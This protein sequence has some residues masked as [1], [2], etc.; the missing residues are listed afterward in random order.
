M[1]TQLMIL[2]IVA[3]MV[4]LAIT[5]M[6]I[7]AL[8]Q[9][10]NLRVQNS[11]LQTSLDEKQQ[12][13]QDLK[14]QTEMHLEAKRK[15][16]EENM[17]LREHVSA[18]NATL[19]AND[20]TVKSL[21]EQIDKLKQD[22]A[23]MHSKDVTNTNEITRLS[24]LLRQA[25]QNHEELLKRQAEL[26][27]QAEETFR[28]IATDILKQNTVDFK[29]ANETR[30]REI[31]TPFRENVDN[32]RK[33]I[34]EYYE[35]GIKETAS[36]KST[37]AELTKLNN[38]LSQEASELATALRGNKR[39]TQGPWGEMILKQILESSGLIEGTNF[40]LQ[41]TTNPDG[42]KIGN[43]YRP[44]ALLYF[45]DN[46][47]LV[48]DSKV[49]ITAY[50]EYAN[51]TD[52]ES[53]QK[54]LA[55]HLCAVES[56]IKALSEKRYQNEVKNSADFVIMFMPNEGAY[57]AAM[58]ADPDL[59]SKAYQKQVL[60]VSPTHLISVLKMM[61]QLWRNDKQNK[62]AIRIAEE[63]GKMIDKLTDLA[64]SV[65]SIGSS[66]K[67]ANKHYETAM[68]RLKEGRGNILD[69]AEKIK[70]LGA[71][72]SKPIPEHDSESDLQLE[73]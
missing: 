51:A 48:I 55:D 64:A 26:S 34:R 10:A 30:I 37:I 31:L 1:T 56:Q 8:R 59:W 23:D 69:K 7:H 32:I 63:T 27:R 28:N 60:L 35:G 13:F 20:D 71:K 54:H 61:E 41:A 57:I 14:N 40:S 53:R 5:A 22:I 3:L 36:L 18:L 44:D 33:S 11:D 38:Q 50:T 49:N 73:E 68:N 47:V 15:I 24:E 4:I 25:E 46:R 21:R 66:L 62:N 70:N 45:P 2:A 12:A 67:S 65:E 72:V 9:N 6:L 42:S 43:D 58:H 52:E 39:N 19:I 16:A 17:S 29:E